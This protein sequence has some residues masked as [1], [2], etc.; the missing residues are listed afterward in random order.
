M[1]GK[2]HDGASDIRA[3]VIAAL[4]LLAAG[5]LAMITFNPALLRDTSF[6]VIA[7]LIFG[8]SGLGAVTAFL[9]GGTRTGSDVMKAQTDALIASAPPVPPTNPTPP[10]EPTP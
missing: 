9:F 10:A 4:F 2:D 7:T 3:L 1:N 8:G 6:M 5:V